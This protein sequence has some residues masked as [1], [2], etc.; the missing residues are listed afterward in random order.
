LTIIYELD[1]WWAP[2]CWVFSIGNSSWIAVLNIR[3]QVWNYNPGT[4]PTY[5]RKF[6]MDSC[7]QYPPPGMELNQG[8]FPIFIGKLSMDSSPQYP[9][10]GME[11]NQGNSLF[12]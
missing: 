5:I 12:L 10:P 2:S 1:V 7:P 6:F 8:T 3:P 9:P 11:L 4:F